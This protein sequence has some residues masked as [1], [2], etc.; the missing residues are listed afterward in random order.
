[1]APGLGLLPDT[2]YAVGE[3][4]LEPGDSLLLYTDGAVEICNAEGLELGTEGLM[5]LVGDGC[6][7]GGGSF[8]VRLDEALLA[9]SNSIRLPD[10]LTIV[11]VQRP[12]TLNQT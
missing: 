1:V 10:D 3:F 8:L 12:V 7:H 4:N 11:C 2:K 9:Y 6:L 5:Q